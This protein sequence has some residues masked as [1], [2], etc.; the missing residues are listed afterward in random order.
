MEQRRALVRVP[1]RRGE[2]MTPVERDAAQAR[3]LA[4]GN[5]RASCA[6]AGV[7]RKTAAKWRSRSGDLATRYQ[8]AHED[9]RDAIRAEIWRRA[10]W[11]AGTS[12]W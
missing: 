5:I 6:A 11:M 7:D 10:A 4:T 2:H 3:F 1:R 12:R 8:D 9:A